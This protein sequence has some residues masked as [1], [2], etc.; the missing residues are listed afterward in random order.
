MKQG[1]DVGRGWRRTV[2]DRDDIF[3]YYLFVDGGGEAEDEACLRAWEQRK[4]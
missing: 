1:R 3:V 2:L 4:K